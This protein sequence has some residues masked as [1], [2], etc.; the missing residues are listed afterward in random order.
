MEKEM[1][2]G[3]RNYRKEYDNYQGSAKQKSNRAKRG[4]A[5]RVMEKKGLVHKGD[6]KDVNH[7]DGNPQNNSTDNLQ[8]MNKSK[9]RSMHE[10]YGAGEEGTNELVMRL[11]KDTPFALCMKKLKKVKK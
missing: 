5:R 6:G 9:N 1:F 4:K 7:K 11:M 8:V 10:E 3:E 2:L